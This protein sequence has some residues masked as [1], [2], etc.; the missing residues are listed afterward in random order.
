MSVNILTGNIFTS[1]LQTLVNTVNCVGVMGAGIALECRLRYPEMFDS[2]VRLCDER[3]VE[4]GL[5]WVYRSP[6]RWILNFPTKMHW[7]YPSKPEYLHLGLEKFVATYRDRGIES[8]AF[9]LLGADR[10]GISQEI[11]LDIMIS[12][13]DK[14]DL[15]VEI[16]KYDP[17]AV[18][19]L[20]EITKKWLLSQN[21]DRICDVTK[22]R[23][24]FV[25]KVVDAMQTHE[26]CQL[27]QLAKVDGI[28]VKTLEKIFGLA[29]SELISG[30]IPVPE[31]Q[32]LL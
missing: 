3:K 18:D 25:S 15:E 1:K 8:I 23:R 26:I 31:Q 22:L 32:S 13:L 19:D 21:I 24:N 14:V 30:S 29:R 16:Y 9:P 20:Y 5:L 28:G 4:I 11:S 6:D 2:Y 7:K 17:A 12:H 27:N 10:G